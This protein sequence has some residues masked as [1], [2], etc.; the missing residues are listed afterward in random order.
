[1]NYR[2]VVL[3]TL[4][5]CIAA[6]VAQ[7]QEKKFEFGSFVGFTASS[8]IDI[9]PKPTGVGMVVTRLSP[10][11]GMSWGLG[12]DYLAPEHLGVGIIWSQQ[13]SQLKGVVAPLATAASAT[14]SDF[15]GMSVFT[16]H[17]IATYRFG[18]KTW[19]VRPFVLGGLGATRYSPGD[20]NSQQFS[21]TS[22]SRK[23]N[24]L[25]EFSTTLGGGIRSYVTPRIGFKFTVRLT[26]T[27][28]PSTIAGIWCGPEGCYYAPSGKI[29]NQCEFSGGLFFRF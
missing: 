18:N 27:Y 21:T 23:F 29:S 15:A 2:R 10:R 28:I 4:V 24:S 7:A 8:G 9:T 13:F 19:K 6:A 25:N 17:I 26:P 12:F 11:S 3:A 22:S 14:E 16:Y 1:M 20:A 5:L